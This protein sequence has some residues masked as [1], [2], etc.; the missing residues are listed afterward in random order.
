MHDVDFLPAE[1]HQQ[2]A[3]RRGR[4]RRVVVLL[5]FAAL[6]G[7]ATFVEHRRRQ[8]LLADLDAV[9]PLHEQAVQR[10]ARL[11]ELQAKAQAARA[12][13]DLYAYLRH[14]WPRTRLLEALLA[15][16]PDEV[17]FEQ[18]EIRGEP[19][20]VR[21]LSAPSVRFESRSEEEQKTRLPPAVGDLKRLRA[22]FDPEQTVVTLIGRTAEGGALHRYLGELGKS[23][24]FTKVQLRSIETVKGDRGPILR[25]QAVVVV[26]P[27]YGQPGG[28]AGPDKQ[29]LAQATA[30]RPSAKPSGNP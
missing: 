8:R 2:R 22:E 30:T 1:Y 15:S 14:P 21:V 18:L 25:F 11:A 3:E 10:T 4:W 24:L 29:A 17:V 6:L 12:E 20:G 13:A 9:Q 26:R 27:G 19:A 5:A 28:P 16:L 23:D 7:A